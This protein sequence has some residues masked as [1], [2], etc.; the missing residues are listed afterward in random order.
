MINCDELF[1]NKTNLKT[2]VFFLLPLLLMFF[3]CS[4]DNE[5]KTEKVALKDITQ[6]VLL[7][8]YIPDTGNNSHRLRYDIKYTNHNNVAVK[9]F[10]NITMNWDGEILTQIKRLPAGYIE[11]EANSSFTE[12]FDVEETFDPQATRVKSIKFVSV[13]FIIDNK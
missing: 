9:G 5:A 11:I 2:K 13:E 1:T 3:G 12:S 8:E 4:S 10:S 6:E 7:F